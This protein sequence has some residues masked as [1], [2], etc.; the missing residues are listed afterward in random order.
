MKTSFDHTTDYSF[1]ELHKFLKKAEAVPDYV[2]EASETK[3]FQ[4]LPKEAFADQG[5][6]AFPK[7]TKAD[8]YLSYIHFLNKKAALKEKYNDFY[9]TE[10]EGKLNK[11]AA[12]FGI[13]EDLA[14]YTASYIKKE[15]SDYTEKAVF[16]KELEDGQTVSLFNFKTA[17]DLKQ[18]ADQFA[19]DFKKLPFDWRFDISK[20]FVKHAQEL[21]LEELPDIICKYAGM[22]YVDTGHVKTELTRR[23]MR[24]PNEQFKENYTKLAEQVDE[25]DSIEDFMKIACTCYYMEKLQGIH[26]NYKTASVL[27]DPVDQIFSVS[28]EKIASDLNVIKLGN[29]FYR[30][31]DLQEV[32]PEIYKQAFGADLDPKDAES[33]MEVLPTMPLS[34]IS[35]FKELSGIRSL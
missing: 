33:L 21:E 10:V 5:N 12:L 6:R 8:V 22:F 27:G 20:S 31:N 14:N 15:A 4:G 2:K 35:L 16:E 23:G 24:N 26:D 1:R 13:T 17:A 7:N 11:A 34:D 19:R 3:D 9:V 29:A 18:A 30:I 28:I 25:C 32:D